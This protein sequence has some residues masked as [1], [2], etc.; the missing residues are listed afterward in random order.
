M[1]K[2]DISGNVFGRLTAIKCVSDRGVKHRRWECSCICGS[3]QS[4]FQDAL[5]SG[6][7]KSC[8]CLRDE[9]TAI[10]SITHGH[11]LGRRESRELKAYNHAKSRCHNQKDPKYKNYGA[12]GIAMCDEW[13]SDASKFINYMGPKPVGMTL[14]RLDVNKGYQPGNCVWAD[15]HTQSRNRT[16]TVFVTY[17]GERMVLKD[18]A[19]VA[20]VSYKSLHRRVKYRGQTAD[21]AVKAL[22]SAPVQSSL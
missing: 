8:G 11:S 2:L 6:R 18:C 13:R 20:G 14:E 22:R 12:R 7:T 1:R 19:I 16:N 15:S 3:V 10:R 21:E 9:M 5:T 17:N 4:V